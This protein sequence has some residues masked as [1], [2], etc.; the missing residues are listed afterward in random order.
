MFCHVNN[1]NIRVS[2]TAPDLP[3]EGVEDGG[4]AL[5]CYGDHHEDGA[6]ERYCLAAEKRGLL[7]LNEFIVI[8][9]SK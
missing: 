7:T 4:A 5:H 8:Y 2:Q 6:G 9:C 1:S 3:G